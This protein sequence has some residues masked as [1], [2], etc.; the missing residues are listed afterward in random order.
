MGVTHDGLYA[1]LKSKY[2]AV[3]LLHAQSI[4]EGNMAGIVNEQ[5]VHKEPYSI[6]DKPFQ[7]V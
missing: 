6:E 2:V 7:S 1:L 4:R 5:I 3:Y